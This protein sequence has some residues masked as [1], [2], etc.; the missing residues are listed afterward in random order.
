VTDVELEAILEAVCVWFEAS[1]SPTDHHGVDAAPLADMDLEALAMLDAQAP[2]AAMADHYGVDLE[3]VP[4]AFL[5][6]SANFP[7]SEH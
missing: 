1:Q 3:G 4:V 2:G 6:V 5:P 7:P